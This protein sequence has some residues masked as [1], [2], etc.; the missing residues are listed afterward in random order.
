MRITI[1]AREDQPRIRCVRSFNLRPGYFIFSLFFF[2]L[3]PLTAY[4]VHDRRQPA[5]QAP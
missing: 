5:Y 1:Q 3:A 2:P 4:L